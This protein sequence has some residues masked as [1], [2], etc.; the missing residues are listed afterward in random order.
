MVIGGVFSFSYFGLEPVSASNIFYVGGVGPGNFSTIQS[1]ISA[2]SAGDTIYVYDEGSPYIENIVIN[3]QIYLVGENKATTVINGGGSGD[4]I[5]INLVN[6]V[7]ISGFTITNGDCGIWVYTSSNTVIKNNDIISNNNEGIG[8]YSSTNMLIQSNDIADNWH[9]VS[10]ESASNNN[11]ILSNNISNN[12]HGVWIWACS[13]IE[14][15]NNSFVN[16]G[17]FLR[18]DQLSDYNSHTISNDNLINSKPLYYYKNSNTVNIDSIPMGQLILANCDDFE[19]KNLVIQNTDVGIQIVYSSNINIS[20]CDVLNNRYGLWFLSSSNN[21]IDNN[22]LNS[23]EIGGIYLT[24]SS[25][26]EIRSNEIKFNYNGIFGISSSNNIVNGNTILSNTKNGIHLRDSNLNFIENNDL[27]SNDENGILIEDNSNNNTINKNDIYLNNQYGISL[28]TSPKSTI[29]NNIIS[30]NLY[31]GIQLEFSSSSTKIIGN[32]ILDNENGILV[33]ESPDNII[34]FNIISTSNSDGIS[35]TWGSDNNNIIGNNVSDNGCG[36]AISTSNNKLFHNNIVSN[37]VQAEDTKDDN[38]WYDDYPSGGNYW[39]D[40]TGEDKRSG[41]NQNYAGSD[42]IG[43]SSYVIEDTRKDRYPLMTK[44][45]QAPRPPSSPKNVYAT[46]EAQQITLIWEPPAFEGGSP[47][48]NY[49]I[50]KGIISDEE[51][52]HQEL[53]TKLFYIDTDV[54]YNVTYYYKISAVNSI[55]E[56]GKSFEVDVTPVPDPTPPGAPLGLVAI[57]GIEEVSLEWSTPVYD[58][59]SPITNY[60]IYKGTTSGP[61]PFFTEIGTELSFKDTNVS[62]GSAYWYY[63][64]AVNNIGVGKQSN[65]VSVQLPEVPFAPQNLD[66]KYGFSY[67][68]LSWKPP[69]LNGGLPI[70]NYLIYKNTSSGSEGS[71]I[72]IGN[73]TFNNDTNVV[74]GAL[75][76]YRVSAVNSVGESPKSN[77]VSVIPGKVPTSPF[78]IKVNAG[79]SYVTLNWSAPENNGGFIITNYIIYRD[80]VAG[81]ESFLKKIGNITYFNDTTV[82]NNITYYYKISAVNLI[83]EGI[84]SN[85]ASATPVGPLNKFPKIKIINPTEGEHVSGVIN[86]NGSASDFDG[87]IKKVEIRIDYGIWITVEGNTS[88]N[89]IWDTNTVP[90]GKHTIYVR[91]MDGFDNSLITNITVFVVDEPPIPP[92]EEN[93]DES[94]E[95]SMLMLITISII[96]VIIIIV[97]ISVMFLMKKKKANQ[98]EKPEQTFELQT[99]SGA[100]QMYE[101]PTQ[102]QQP[103]ST[104]PPLPLQ[105]HQQPPHQH[106][107]GL[108]QTQSPPGFTGTPC[109]NCDKI[110]P[111]IYQFCPYCKMQKF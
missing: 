32:D 46:A 56:S 83:G 69:N 59:G 96:I 93:E 35:I 21:E 10:L 68:N 107:Q 30:S 103:P 44:A 13:N 24:S 6:S 28:W 11:Q 20:G 17:V 67:V 64:S 76:Y 92:V 88:W 25:N 89:Y 91:A 98:P 78:M 12:D 4:V 94:S 62:S 99:P 60:K 110:S 37:T 79:D 31:D 63:V 9:G 52:F 109:K 26:N 65:K 85:S 105:L 39:G 82:I 36:I 41:V 80:E 61:L 42:G 74:N 111:V 48:T 3:K 104:L 51:T 84:P 14:I 5:I 86:I 95:S 57:A 43:D 45:P 97:I 58:G 47:V 50:F 15:T 16:D 73:V 33:H 8:L 23:N 27:N 22:K 81:N 66:A 77:M 106:V 19:V 34:K 1:A 71:P 102:P 55:G 87:A 101:H 29:T 72:K 100:S 75:Y 53:D 18:G 2:A 70:T 49:K 108:P 38:S 7:E 40:Y 54:Y 90:N